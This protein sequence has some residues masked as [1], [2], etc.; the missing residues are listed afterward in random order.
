AWQG[1][2]ASLFPTVDTDAGYERRKVAG[3]S[4]SSR[5][6]NQFSAGFD[7]S[8]EIDLFG[9]IRRS[10]EQ[11]AA[12]FEAA[13]ADLRNAL[14]SVVAELARNYVDMRSL[15]ARVAVA[16]D[17]AKSQEQTLQIVQWRFQAGLTGALDVEQATYNLAQTPSRI[18][19]PEI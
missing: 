7:S 12:A 10:S 18:P 8:W 16:V 2:K 9:G 15:Q 11:A 14:V 17:N 3:N 13:G 19:A 4:T 5:S 1:A 6:L